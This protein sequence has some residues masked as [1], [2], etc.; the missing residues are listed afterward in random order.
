MPVFTVDVPEGAAPGAKS[1]VLAE[2]TA[3]LDE[4]YHVPDTRGWIREYRTEN[5]ATD[6]EVGVRP[7]RPV[8]TLEVPELGNLDSKRA[9]VRRVESAIAEGYAG[10]ADVDEVLI[11]I[12]HYPLHDVGW[13]S[14]LQS[15]KPEIVEAMAN[16][17][18]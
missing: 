14:S 11:L 8:C 17:N 3:A 5:V 6:G 2:I 10:L 15:D 9:L 12:N 16:L 1:K 4:A 18:P 7:I 13:R